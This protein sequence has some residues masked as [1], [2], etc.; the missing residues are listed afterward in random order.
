MKFDRIILGDGNNCIF[1]TNTEKTQLNNNVIICGSS[2]S[3]K[4]MSVTE[5]RLLET[6]NSSLVVNL[7]KRKLVAQY[8]PLFKERGY[9]VLDL[10]FVNPDKSDVSYDPLTYVKNYMD[11][12]F[13]AQ[14]IVKADPRSEH[15]H[16]DPYWEQSAISLL[17]AEIAYVLITK[18]NPSFNDVLNF[19][20]ELV[21]IDEDT[22]IST[23]MDERFSRLKAGNL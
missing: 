3:G 18:D 6:F 12:T 14:A 10:N 16:A 20:A 15:S 23:S 17:S 2:G 5:M 22:S 19:Q 11:I 1:S 13:L 8:T 4:T 21:I 7:S 9:K